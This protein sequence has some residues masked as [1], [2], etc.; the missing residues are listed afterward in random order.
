MPFG[1][2]DILPRGWRQDEID[3][4]VPGW[5]DFPDVYADQVE[6]AV[7]GS[8]FVE[9]GSWFGK[10]TIAMAKKIEK[11]GKRIRFDAVDTWQGSEN[12]PDSIEIVRQLGGSIHHAYRENLLRCGVADIVRDVVSDSVAAAE[13][14]D[15]KS[16][17]FVFIDAEHT[18]DATLRNLQAWWPKIRQGGTIAGHDFDRYEVRQ[19][20]Y[21]FSNAYGLS[22]EQRGRCFQIK[23]DAIAHRTNRKGQNEMEIYELLGRSQHDLANLRQEYANLLSLI[24]R[25]KSGDIDPERVVINVSAQAW[26]ILPEVSSPAM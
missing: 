4:S 6:S 10:S 23:R 21:E 11:S 14:Y 26:T 7:D 18:H 5:F 13:H 8:H 3:D 25:I 22:V 19:A 12:E 15:D 20:V 24:E 17:D 9:V 16:L 2:D 1:I